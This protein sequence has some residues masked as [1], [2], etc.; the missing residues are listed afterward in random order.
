MQ[1][2]LMMMIMKSVT[3]DDDRDTY[4]QDRHD[5]CGGHAPAK[6]APKRKIPKIKEFTKWCK[7]T[8]EDQMDMADRAYASG[9]LERKAYRKMKICYEALSDLFENHWEA[10]MERAK[11]NNP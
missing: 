11:R 2:E 8:C 6:K 4:E 1:E 9:N 7:D 5:C 10:A 3:D